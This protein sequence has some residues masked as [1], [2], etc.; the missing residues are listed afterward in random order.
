VSL[1]LCVALL[2]IIFGLKENYFYFDKRDSKKLIKKNNRTE[3]E[4][5][6]EDYYFY[7]NFE[8]D[9]MVLHDINKILVWYRFL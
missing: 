7:G 3:Y 6:L 2:R 1:D 5:T 9:F 4:R 8:Y